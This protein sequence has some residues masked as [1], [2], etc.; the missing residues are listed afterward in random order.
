MQMHVFAENISCGL[1]LMSPTDNASVLLHIEELFS[2]QCGWVNGKQLRDQTSRLWTRT[3][4]LVEADNDNVC[5]C[6]FKQPCFIC[7]GL[8]A[9]LSR[10]QL[11]RCFTAEGSWEI[12]HELFYFFIFFL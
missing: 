11:S 9:P 10:S 12:N 5:N 4:E 7:G 6:L 8:H 2:N 3:L 1:Y